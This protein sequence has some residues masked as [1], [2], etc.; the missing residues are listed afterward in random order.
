MRTYLSQT[1]CDINLLIKNFEHSSGVSR[2]LLNG[3]CAN[4]SQRDRLI[5]SHHEASLHSH[6]YTETNCIT[7]KQLSAHCETNAL[8]N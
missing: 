3:N 6:Y 7:D 4:M 2:I 1:Y 5:L 8:Y